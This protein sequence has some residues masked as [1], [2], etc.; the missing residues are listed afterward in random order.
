MINTIYR[1]QSVWALLFALY[2]GG[3]TQPLLA[4]TVV[5]TYLAPVMELW[6]TDPWGGFYCYPSQY[7][8]LWPAEAAATPCADRVPATDVWYT[9][10]I[11]QGSPAGEQFVR[12]Y[13]NYDQQGQFVGNGV[14]VI[15]LWCPLG[16]QVSS[17]YPGWCLVSFQTPQC[18]PNVLDSQKA[19]C[20]SPP[21]DSAGAPC[22]KLCAGDP[23]NIGSG[24]TYE[25]ATDYHGDGPFP[26]IFSRAY[27]SALANESYSLNGGTV[28]ENIGQG[29]STNVGAHL[30][31]SQYSPQVLATSCGGYFCPPMYLPNGDYT[32]EITIWHADGSQEQFNYQVSN[33]VVPVPGTAFNAEPGSA[34][35]LSFVNLPAPMTGTGYEYLRNDGYIEFYDANGNLL[36][37]QNPHG[38]M[39]TYQYAGGALL[40]SVTDPFGRMLKF[41]YNSN[42]Q[43]Q[44][45][46][47]PAGG[48]YTYS[49]DSN[50]NLIEVTY[51]DNSA[52]Q[53][54][55]QDSSFP[56]VLTG[57][58]DE[59]GNQHATWNYDS[60]GRA[61]SS[62]NGSNADPYSIV[63]NSDGSADV[64][65]PTG[66][67]RHLTFTSVNDA[68]VFSTASA[69][70]TECGD[71]SQS[72]SYD[73]NGHI[74]STTDFNGNVTQYSYD[75]AG[76]LLSETDAYGTPVAQTLST[77]WDTTRNLPALITEP[78]RTISY[79]R[80]SNVWTTSV[81]DTATEVSRTITY[82]YNSSGLLISI[83]DPRGNVTSFTYDNQ[84][85]IA[86]I[87]NALGQV[88]QIASYDANGNPLTIIDP[89]GVTTTLTYDARQRLTSCTVA[90]AKTTYTY[91][92]VGNLTQMTL[93]TGAYLSYTYDTAHRLTAVSD[94][95]GNKIVYTLDALGNRIDEQTY[96]P[97]SVLRRTLARTFDTLNHL[98]TITGGAGQVSH[99]T[100]DRNGNTTGITD[101]MNNAT[102]Q[103]FDPLN[104]LISQV[105][106]LH[107]TTTYGYDA[108][109]R[110]TSVTD[111]RGLSTT[112][113]YDAFG[114]ITQLVSPDTG[115][116][117]DTYDL[118]GNRLTQTDARGIT[119]QYQYDAL[120]RLTTILYPA[121]SA[122]NATFTYDQGT[123]GIGRLTG[124]SNPTGSTSLTY[125][126]QGDLIQKSETVNGQ[127]FTLSYQYDT[128]SNLT[129]IT[130]PDG[131]QVIYNR[132]AAEN[133]TSVVSSTGGTVVTGVTYEPFGPITGLTYGNGLTETRSYDQ[134]YRLT[135]LTVP[136]ILSWQLGYNADDDITGITDN[137]ISA[138]SQTLGYDAL[139]HLT[140]ASS[141]GLYGSL[142]DGYDANGNRDT[143]TL[144]GVNTTLTIAAGSNQLLRLS[145]GQTATYSYDADGNLIS[146]GINTYTYDDT[147]RLTS[148]TTG[149][150]TDT[151]QY[152]ALG[153]RVEKTVGGVTTLFVYDEA[154][155]LLGEYSS[156]GQLIAEHIWLNN[157]PI[158]VITPNELYYVQTG[159]L[160]TPRAITNS[161]Q[162]LIWEW[163]SDPFGNGA[164]N[165]N[166]SGLGTFT[167]N[168]RFPGQYYAAETGLNYNYFRDYD[169]AIGRYIESDPAGLAGGINTYT[170]VSN[171]PLRYRDPLG[172]NSFGLAH[173]CGTKICFG[174]ARAL[175]GNS[176][177]L[178]HTGAYPNIKIT[179]NSAAAIPQ[180]FGFK[181]SRAFAP[182]AG[183][184]SGYIGG[185]SPM[186]INA[187]SDT[188][189]GQSPIPGMNVRDA[190]QTLYPGLL[191][192]ELPG[193]KRDL[194]IVPVILSVPAGVPCP[195]GT[196]DISQATYQS[197]LNEIYQ[198]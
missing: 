22:K 156:T 81:T 157:R 48:V 133:I 109:D 14:L 183:N 164:P 20:V 42:D 68:P 40:T 74:S 78:G 89:N 91:D 5:P 21:A 17:N 26:L 165:P 114:D 119:T 92:K 179:A 139:N 49:Y 41:T 159:Q 167:Y 190:L 110:V 84:G 192:L 65:E 37:V 173:D 144:N 127:P 30:Y 189:G 36:A 122:L 125:N 97:S 23:I 126:A 70:C 80:Q 166:P 67:V 88:T 9:D 169:P 106:P 15:N 152:N 105:N 155:H 18:S 136:T 146:D 137:L 107:G 35:E 103:Q 1:R 47:N 25:E 193:A 135:A 175:Q 63:Y 62:Q 39:R 46:T 16:G 108:L 134:D 76:R 140:G 10:W 77:Q 7:P 111:P 96:D 172:L 112:Y 171:N 138:D 82:N 161:S 50:N 4:T 24:N 194:G 29:W 120:N 129:A 6:N 19:L 32:I 121:D 197:Y 143:E 151:Y 187:I 198:P 60:Q 94:S 196:T 95:D 141:T 45:M 31:I 73:G 132:D 98:Q 55:Y 56:N 115:T 79:N 83:T 131:T 8:D 116:T 117:T 72:I 12:Y 11:M 57:I 86:T 75:A 195:T 153:E 66:E 52:V 99:Y 51:P 69:P 33:N 162:K 85:D 142:S 59:N 101:P 61:I 128:D 118:A 43:I 3:W 13:K 71:K 180:Q 181:S 149:S 163:Q 53:Y 54:Q 124:F 145:G 90:G 182:Y 177:F 154:G 188:I 104:R 168:L 100:E 158:G 38:L 102:G 184:V 27:N 178:G 64:T 87:T 174:F 44:T 93:P 147:N 170:Y 191:I 28:N 176:D 185:S 113:D 58:L 123:D 186:D 150:G 160:G 2:L 148:V 34:G 130:Y